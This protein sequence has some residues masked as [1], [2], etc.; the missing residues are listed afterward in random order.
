[1]ALLGLVALKH[2]GNPM[3]PLCDFTT[4]PSHTSFWS[5][6]QGPYL[7]IKECNILSQT[8]ANYPFGGSCK[9]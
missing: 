9:L 2:G 5:S 8:E 3:T 7:A 6:V 4:L 1:M